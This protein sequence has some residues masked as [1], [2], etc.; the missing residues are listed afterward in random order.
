M[1]IYPCFSQ[2]DDRHQACLVRGTTTANHMS[3]SYKY[4]IYQFWEACGVGFRD[5]MYSGVYQSILR[6]SPVTKC[7]CAD[8]RLV[9]VDLAI[10][11]V[12]TEE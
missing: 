11:E 3:F 12:I 10:P 7:S 8:M 1:Y 2:L 9:G 5:G 6:T 4:D